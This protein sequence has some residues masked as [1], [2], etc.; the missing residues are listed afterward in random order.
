[1]RH[2]DRISTAAVENLP[3]Q[4]HAS[5]PII[6]PFSSRLVQKL[7][8]MHLMML[9][10][11]SFAKLL[12]M[13]LFFV[14]TATGI[15]IHFPLA[16]HS[17]S[18][19]CNIFTKQDPNTQL[20]KHFTSPQHRAKTPNAPIPPLPPS[21]GWPDQKVQQQLHSSSDILLPFPVTLF[22]FVATISVLAAKSQT[23][24]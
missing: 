17:L 15:S 1:M 16:F 9:P 7:I 18:V 5:H 23:L 13:T 10:A 20:I 4:L 3:I 6:P 22:L 14:P 11:L 12:N 24:I 2:L 21:I 19:Y 8:A